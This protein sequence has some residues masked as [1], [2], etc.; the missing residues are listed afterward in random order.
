MIE[1][2]QIS[3]RLGDLVFDARAAGPA[4][5][6]RVFLCHGFPQTSHCWHRL[7]PALARAGYRAIAPDGRGLSP[8]A[9]PE[10]LAD[11]HVDHLVA[12]VIGFAD[13]SGADRFH[14]V[15]HDWGGLQ[16]WQVAGRHPDRVASFT[17]L[18]TP[19]NRA[20]REALEDPATGQADR[21][22]YFE[23]FRT[24]G[25]GEDMWLA[26]GEEGLRG[27]YQAAGLTREEAEPYVEVFRDRAA[28]TGLLSWYRAGEPTWDEGLG[29]IQTPTLYCWGSEDAALGP[30]AAEK[31]ADWID[32]PYRF[33]VFE[34]MGH[35]LPEH[36]GARLEAL[37]LDHLARH[38]V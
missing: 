19:H 25:S 24:P 37:L 2:E 29:R 38:P 7:M 20:F 18:S 33:E 30:A 1:I 15:G 32:G 9:R 11:Y 28:L 12:D 17:S 35:W 36:G 4:T 8:G 13:A 5:G 26:G 27:L 6:D 16:G 10:R 14:L 21:S 34:G 3:L 22:G 31:T 23:I